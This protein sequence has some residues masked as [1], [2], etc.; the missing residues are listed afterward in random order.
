M[1]NTALRAGVAREIISPPKGIYLIGYGDRTKGNTGIHDDLSATA[2]VLDDG[3]RRL[4]LVSCD[5]LFLNEFIVDRV[6]A[7]VGRRTDVIMCCSHTHAGP[8]AYADRRSGRAR[9]AYINTLVAKIA[10]AVDQAGAS[11]APAELAWGQTEAS[12]AV[13]RRERQPD[14]DVT[15]GVNADGTIDQSVSILR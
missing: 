5:I 13:N 10:R 14:G 4:A 15:I 6:R 1:D 11:L 7:Q 3:Q 8:I 2:L 12:I 9:F